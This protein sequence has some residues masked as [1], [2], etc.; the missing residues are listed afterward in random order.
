MTVGY[1]NL[2][3]NQYEN[4]SIVSS[5]SANYDGSPQPDFHRY[6]DEP[7]RQD[8]LNGLATGVNRSIAEND[9]DSSMMDF[10]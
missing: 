9:E 7:S 4:G 3:I 5:T 8:S 10:L 2:F 1:D 6:S